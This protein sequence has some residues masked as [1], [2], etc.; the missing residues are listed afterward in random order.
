MLKNRIRGVLNPC[1][2]YL[3]PYV[4]LRHEW[5]KLSDMSK[6]P[7]SHAETK[8]SIGVTEETSVTD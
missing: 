8:F 5:T 4:V 7:S 3:R 2:T 1:P 6:A